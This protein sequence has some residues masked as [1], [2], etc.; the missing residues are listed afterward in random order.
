MSI[1]QEPHLVANGRR[2]ASRAIVLQSLQSI[3]AYAFKRVIVPITDSFFD[4]RTDET[5][6]GLGVASNADEHAFDYEPLGFAMVTIEQFIGGSI[7]DNNMIVTTDEVMIA[8]QVEPYYPNLKGRDRLLQIPEWQPKKGD[9]FCLLLASDDYIY[10]ECVG[11]TGSS[12]M[13][14]FGAKYVFNQ[15][16]N[17]DF[18]P[19]FDESKLDDVGALD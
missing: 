19:V 15:K 12:I 8:G 2:L 6:A 14:D 5:W 3:P 1:R 13:A 4:N 11:R 10:M 17:L 18:L 7:H 9:L 16:F